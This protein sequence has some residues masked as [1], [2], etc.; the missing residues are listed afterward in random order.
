MFGN[1]VNKDLSA[2]CHGELS[3]HD[4]SGV[5][6]HLIGCQQCRAEFEEIKLGVKFAESLPQ[7]E[8]PDS[9]W[10]DLELLLDKEARSN[11]SV[12]FGTA[13]PAWLPASPQLL[14]P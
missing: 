3:P 4:A 12:S 13:R 9:L 2:Y 6:E 11:C 5:A 14:L 10:D 8:A 1:H 7:L